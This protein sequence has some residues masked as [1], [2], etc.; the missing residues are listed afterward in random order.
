MNYLNLIKIV[1]DIFKE[2]AFVFW[3]HTKVTLFLDL[4]CSYS[5]YRPVMDKLLN[6]EYEYNPSKQLGASKAHSHSDSFIFIT[7]SVMDA[8]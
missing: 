2:I 7:H 4:G 3:A 5:R 1:D 6:T 8:I